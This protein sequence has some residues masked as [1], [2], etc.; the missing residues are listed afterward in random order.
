MA[1]IGDVFPEERRGRATGSLMSAFALASVAG[2]PFGLYLG[3]RYGWHVPFL[4]LVGLGIPV[5]ILAAC[6][7]PALEHQPGKHSHP[8]RSLAATFAD[9]NHLNAFA[10]IGTLSIGGFAVIPYISPYLV[11]NVGVAET[12][13]P[14]VYIVAGTLTLFAAPWIGKQADR[15]GKLLV[16]RLI[17]PISALLL[18]GITYLPVVPAFV[19]VTM[20]SL[21]MVSNAG[22]MIAA[23]AM[24][25]GSV[26]QELR[27]GFMSANSSVQHIA[28]GIG[29]YIGGLIITQAPD[30]T[31]QRYGLVGWI[32]AITTLLTL[33]LAGRLRLAEGSKPITGAE[34]VA[35]A[36]EAT[37]DVGEPLVGA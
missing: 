22:R 8:L 34:S 29:A 13:L 5:L 37:C 23:M 17:A 31:M 4:A 24:I 6:A 10:L 19:A 15:Y 26:R 36:A 35:A 18:L 28:S 3:T 16:Y 2:V 9:T 25:T 12:Q 27:G 7:L 32:A 30:G 11:A 33:W 20:V 21:L 1:I 14:F